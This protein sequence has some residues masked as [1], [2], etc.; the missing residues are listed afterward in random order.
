MRLPTVRLAALGMIVAAWWG[1]AFAQEVALDGGLDA[2]AKSVAF[3]SFQPAGDHFEFSFPSLDTTSAYTRAT[4]VVEHLPPSSAIVVS[5]KRMAGANAQNAHTYSY[6]NGSD[7]AEFVSGVVFGSTLTVAVYAPDIADVK[8]SVTKIFRQRNP[9]RSWE[10]IF[11]EDD[12]RPLLKAQRADIEAAARAVV[13]ISVITPNWELEN[14]SG[15][16]IGERLA[17]TNNHCVATAADCASASLVFDYFVDKFES[18]TMGAQVGCKQV[19]LTDYALDFSILE[20]AEAGPQGLAALALLA[21]PPEP[22]EEAVLIHHPGGEPKMVSINGCLPI[23][24]EVT[25]RGDP[26]SQ[27]DFSHRCDSAGGSSGSPILVRSRRAEGEFC[28]GG[29]HHWGF[30]GSGEFVDLNRAVMASAILAQAQQADIALPEC[31]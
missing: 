27:Q 6:P 19:L 29:L 16:V 11:G 25:G 23:E 18:T 22:D 2:T 1:A 3:T 8:L 24:L 15:F 30:V 12:E 13:Y 4:I 10:S 5:G 28:V 7:A 17:M 21:V 26:P 14:C 20:M 31:Q 9:T